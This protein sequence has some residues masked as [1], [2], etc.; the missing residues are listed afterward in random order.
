MLLSL[1]LLSPY[2]EAAPAGQMTKPPELVRF[3]EATFPESPRDHRGWL[4]T[5]VEREFP[6]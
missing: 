3:V 5:F 2:A 6:S 4:W 1:L